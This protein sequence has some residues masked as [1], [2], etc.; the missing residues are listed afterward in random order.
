MKRTTP[1]GEF[2]IVYKGQ[3]DGKTMGGT[4]ETPMGAGEWKAEKVE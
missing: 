1:N 3:I 2:V 4:T